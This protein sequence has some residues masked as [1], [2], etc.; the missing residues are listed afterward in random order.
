MRRG[1]KIGIAVAVVVIVAATEVA[2]PF[3]VVAPA[4]GAPP[5]AAVI[6]IVV[7]IVRPSWRGDGEVAGR[8]LLDEVGEVVAPAR[9]RGDGPADADRVHGDLAL[10]APRGHRARAEVDAQVPSGLGEAD[11]APADPARRQVGPRGQLDLQP[12]SA[13]AT[14]DEQDERQLAAIEG[15]GPELPV[16]RRGGS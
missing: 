12:L 8:G 3:A 14:L 16:S 6:V 9:R 15:A 2:P 10:A 7:I 11:G 1:V 4:S 5:P 13:A